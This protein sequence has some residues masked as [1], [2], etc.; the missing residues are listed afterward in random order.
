[1]FT[2][3]W[4]TP[5]SMGPVGRQA[6]LVPWGFVGLTSTEALHFMSPLTSVLTERIWVRIRKFGPNPLKDNGLVTP[7]IRVQSIL[8]GRL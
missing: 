7:H 8:A 1:M 4:C 3:L 6:A 5:D 2:V